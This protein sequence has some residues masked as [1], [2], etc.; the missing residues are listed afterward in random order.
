MERKIKLL[1]I[2]VQALDHPLGTKLV[3]HGPGPTHHH[4]FEEYK[5][6][7]GRNV[8]E[9]FPH[10]EPSHKALLAAGIPGIE[11]VGGD[12]DEI[13]GKR[14]TFMAYPWRWPGGDG[15]GIRLV[16][17]IDPDQTFTIEKGERYASN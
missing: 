12:I 14:C 11:N 16:A 8:M 6:E 10:W 7:T 5:K 15:C 13:T 4:L 1:G 3:D 17:V 9:D 2:D